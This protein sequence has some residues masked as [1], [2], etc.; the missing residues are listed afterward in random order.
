MT[1]IILLFL[2]AALVTMSC[3]E[4]VF[5][6]IENPRLT[7]SDDTIHFDTVFT[8]LGT[9]TKELRVINPYNNW[10]KIQRIYLGGGSESPFRINIDGEPAS[11]VSNLQLAPGDSI[12]IFVDVVI[13]PVG[14]NNPVAVTD[15][16]ML[17]TGNS[18]QI[19]NLLAWGQDIHLLS[20]ENV[21]TT[22]WGNDKPWVVYNSVLV[23]TGEVLTIEAGA[24]VL[25]HRGS[26]MYVAG[27]LV[28]SGEYGNKVYFG[29]DRT[30]D[31]Y[32]EI[33]GQWNGIYFINVSRDNIIDNA[34]V[35][36]GVSGIHLG[37]LG[38]VDDPPGLVITNSVVR[39]M[40]VSGLSS[41]GG[42]I[43]A[44]NCEVSHCGFYNL[45]LV[46]GGRYDFT[47]CTISNLWEYSV[48]TTPSVLITDFYDYNG[49]RYTGNLQSA[50][51]SNS[52]LY[53]N[54][55]SEI[56]ILP[57][58][59]GELLNCSF[60]FSLVKIDTG[61][62]LWNN[63]ELGTALV[64]IEPGFIGFNNLDFRPDT[65]SSLTGAA[66]PA[67]SLVY[68]ADLRGFDR[69]LDVG[70]DIGAYERQPGEK[71]DKYK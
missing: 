40:T 32:S 43:S 35:E 53:G 62:P 12:F 54:L 39:N 33:P 48:R 24:R 8:S 26:T 38:S 31:Y 20:G 36:N 42:D 23:D 19:V 69:F 1:R 55:Q 68:P 45:F 34:V 3:T 29:S 27:T 44:V 70:P 30:E 18:L 14:D 57:D 13:D 61:D 37:N 7:F 4:K 5:V 71:S 41:L 66:D 58:Q 67:V 10:L 2:L 46:M 25:F 9:V 51:F 15:S 59:A 11:D 52:V 6:D 22:T 16:I 50:S 64:N 28:V 56:T 60:D 63:Y 65:L 47:H 17:I 49:T 21:T